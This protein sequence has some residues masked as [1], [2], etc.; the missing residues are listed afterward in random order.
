MT[1]KSYLFLI[2]IILVTYFYY[3]PVENKEIKPNIV[4]NI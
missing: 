3:K 1:E 4:Y 2:A